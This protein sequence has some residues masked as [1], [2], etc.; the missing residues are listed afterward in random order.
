MLRFEFSE[1]WVQDRAILSQKEGPT[2]LVVKRLRF[3]DR[4]R[5][6]NKREPCDSVSMRQFTAMVTGW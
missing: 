4:K 3:L 2:L 6:G 1:V 5:T